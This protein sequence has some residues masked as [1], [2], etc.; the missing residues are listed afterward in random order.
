MFFFHLLLS[1]SFTASKLYGNYWRS[2]D[3]M[4]LLVFFQNVVI[5][6]IAG[7]LANEVISMFFLDQQVMKSLRSYAG[8]IWNYLDLVSLPCS[9]AR[10]LCSFAHALSFWHPTG[11]S[12][13]RA[14]FYP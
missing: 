5:I 4:A 8:D 2:Q 1:V 7:F 13:V 11:L 9:F 10:D 14:F 3:E 12:V 6:C